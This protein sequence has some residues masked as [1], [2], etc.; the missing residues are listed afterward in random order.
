MR[1]R[2]VPLL[3][4]AA[5]LLG[6]NFASAAHADISA[7]SAILKG[8]NEVPNAGDPAAIGVATVTLDSATGQVCVRIRVANMAPATAAHIHVGD[9]GVAGPVVIGLPTPTNGS[10]SGCITASS[11]ALVQSII[12]NPGHF[13]VNVHNAAYPGGAARGQLQ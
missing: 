10:S 11:T 5:A 4:L 9:A 13:Y 7:R 12:N 8:S 6:T 1:R 3:S 2:F